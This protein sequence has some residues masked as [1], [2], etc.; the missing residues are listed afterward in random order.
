MEKTTKRRQNHA[1]DQCRKSKRACDTRV[2]PDARNYRTALYPGQFAQDSIRTPS[3][4]YCLKTKKKC[5]F[6]WAQAQL[7]GGANKAS[8]G[9]DDSSEPAGAAQQFYGPVPGYE[10]AF[11]SRGEADYG[12]GMGPGMLAMKQ[13]LNPQLD[14]FPSPPLD[15]NAIPY[16]SPASN[17]TDGQWMSS[18]GTSLDVAQQAFWGSLPNLSSDETQ[19]W[20]SLSEEGF[21]PSTDWLGRDPSLQN[22]DSE[23]TFYQDRN[24]RKNSR[25]D[26]WTNWPAPTSTLSILTSQEQMLTISNNAM[27]SDNL[28]RIYHDVLEHNLSCWLAEETCPYGSTSLTLMRTSTN[29]ERLQNELGSTWSNKIYGRVKLLDR[30]AQ[31]NRLLQLRPSE[32]QAASKA[33]DLVIMAFA[34][35][36]AQ[37]SYRQSEKYKDSQGESPNQLGSDGTPPPEEFDRRIQR[38]LWAQAKAALENVSGLECFRVVCAELIFGLCQR[39]MDGDETSSWDSGGYEAYNSSNSVMETLMGRLREAIENEEPPIF[40]ERGARKIHALKCKFDLWEAGWLDRNRGRTGGDAA[41]EIK[42]AKR[43]V[44][45]LYWLSVMFDTISSSMNERP[46]VVADEEC[47]HDAAWDMQKLGDAI[48]SYGQTTETLPQR[49]QVNLF[50]QD[51]LAKPSKIPSWPCSYDDAAATVT[52]SAPVKVLLFRH[53]SYLQSAIRRGRRGK[54]VEDIINASM[55][56]YKYWNVTYGPFHRSLVRDYDAVPPRVQSWFVCIFSHWHLAVLLLAEAISFIDKKQLGIEE[57]RRKRLNANFCRQMAKSSAIEISDIAAVSAPKHGSNNASQWTLPPGAQETPFHS[58]TH[59]GAILTEPWTI[60]IIRAFTK[61]AAIHLERA[62]ELWH[63]RSSDPSG[64]RGEMQGSLDRCEYCTRALWL[65]GKKSDMARK[66]AEI[67]SRAH[68]EMTG[69][70]AMGS[71][72]VPVESWEGILNW[73]ST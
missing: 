42:E 48:D 5:T 66:A 3:C 67:L 43:T 18:S 70:I 9:T 59:E 68:S 30:V 50:I 53:V 56:I 63:S 38:T 8:P 23:L 64:G 31:R 60:L 40:M 51:D 4:T 12:L 27:I 36:W 46:V 1:C 39:P 7:R 21:L 45:L 10:G 57:V 37:G 6:V 52:K 33:L 49:W 55:L 35:Q 17:S 22:A 16:A 28:L 69:Q 65:L 73:I 58:V 25:R 20:G 34:S 13:Q 72:V 47:Q 15:I 11:M 26:S 29:K 44:Q 24:A 2:F 54:A 62:E 71:V 19:S 14:M 32:D 41:A 61:A